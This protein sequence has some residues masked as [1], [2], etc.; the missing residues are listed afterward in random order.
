[1]NRIIKTVSPYF[2]SLNGI[3]DWKGDTGIMLPQYCERIN[4]IADQKIQ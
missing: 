2:L 1:M 4:E 3:S